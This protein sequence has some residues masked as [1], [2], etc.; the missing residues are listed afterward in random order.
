MIRVSVQDDNQLRINSDH[1]KTLLLGVPY[2]FT[3][4]LPARFELKRRL[5]EALPSWF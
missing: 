3:A 2:E 4:W 1:S 5:S